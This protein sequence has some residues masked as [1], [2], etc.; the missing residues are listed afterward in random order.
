MDSTARSVSVG[1]LPASCDIPIPTTEL[2][3]GFDPNLPQVAHSNI[4]M[5]DIDLDGEINS[6]DPVFTID[7]TPYMDLVDETYDLLQ[8]MHFPRAKYIP[9][10]MFRYYCLQAWWNRVLWLEGK[11][12]D[13]LDQNDPELG[14]QVDALCAYLELEQY[15]LPKPIAQYLTGIGDFRLGNDTFRFSRIPVRFLGNRESFPAAPRGWVSQTRTSDFQVNNSSS[16]WA[17]AQL[18]VPGVFTLAVVNELIE[19]ES[20]LGN[21]ADQIPKYQLSD[22]G[23]VPPAGMKVYPTNNIIGWN[24]TD[25]R[26]Y[27]ADPRL[28]QEA[29]TACG[30]SNNSCPADTT[31]TFNLSPGTMQWVSQSLQDIHG[32]PLH[33]SLELT[34][35]TGG[36][37]IQAYFLH[38]GNSTDHKDTDNLF[39]TKASADLALCVS[40]PDMASELLTAAFSFGYRIERS[41]VSCDNDTPGLRS[42][43]QPWIYTDDH[44]DI[45]DPPLGT[46]EYMDCTFNSYESSWLNIKR[47]TSSQAMKRTVALSA[48]IMST[49]QHTLQPT[50]A[51]ASISTF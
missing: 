41:M 31:S 32:L 13:G 7:A 37:P 17:Y 49:M 3:D 47:F 19:V 42:N 11:S 51:S 28:W 23:P 39:R 30:W 46:M 20:Q 43:Y 45:H 6:A 14:E 22:I 18:P 5:T 25:S 44:D 24:T 27:Q 34:V 38:L 29:F 35:S 48:A 15:Q 21:P 36:N 1:S 12:P 9:R 16:F 10:S 26:Y 4:E 50:N 40:G 33:S 8:R 2:P